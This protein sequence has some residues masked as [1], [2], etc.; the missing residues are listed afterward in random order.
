MGFS[1]PQSMG[2]FLMEDDK[3]KITITLSGE[4]A[5]GKTVMAVFLMNLMRSMGASVSLHGD[6]FDKHRCP[7]SRDE[8]IQYALRV[9]K[10]FDKMDIRI[11]EETPKYHESS[12]AIA[13]K[14]I[15]ILSGE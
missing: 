15:R 13:R 3:V 2:D 10:R 9:P 4:R 7:R 5:C 8:Y 14:N 12:V 11:V 1:S 6:D